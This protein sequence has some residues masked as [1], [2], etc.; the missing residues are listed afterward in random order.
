MMDDEA[1]FLSKDG[2]KRILR[3]GSRLLTVAIFVFLFYRLSQLGWRDLWG[4]LPTNPLFYALFVVIYLTLPVSELLVYRQI[5]RLPFR[6]GFRALLKKRVFNEEIAGYSG[7]FYLFWWLRQKF[8]VTRGDAFRAVRD[9]NILSSFAS[10]T[11]AF[12]LLGVLSATG[13]LQLQDLFDNL[14]TAYVTIGV[15]AVLVVGIVGYRFRHYLFSLPRTTAYR[16]LGIHYGRLL[17]ANALLVVQ[18]MV[19]VPGIALAVWLT[20]L[21]MRIVLNRIPFLPSRDLFFLGASVEL[22]ELIG[23]ATTQIAGMLLVTSVLGRI[24]NAALFVMVHYFDSEAKSVAEF[25]R[26]ELAAEA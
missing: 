9:N 1:S 14:N 8:G 20:Y 7:E 11:V 15:I 4:A 10:T 6:S 16:I 13:L 17:I 26:D 18:W 12:T 3:W 22:S 23:T 21:C 2:T 24:A 19:G 25:D 5:W